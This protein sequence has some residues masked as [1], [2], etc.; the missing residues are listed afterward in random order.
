MRPFWEKV[1]E[2]NSEFQRNLEVLATISIKDIV[3]G[4]NLDREFYIF[5]QTLL[6]R[7]SVHIKG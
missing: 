3:S 1:L 2:I 5:S 6:Q 4:R 7:V